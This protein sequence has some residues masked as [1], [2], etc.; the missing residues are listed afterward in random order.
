MNYTTIVKLI[1]LACLIAVLLTAC[2]TAAKPPVINS[3]EIPYYAINQLEV[4]N[5]PELIAKAVVI[6]W[7]QC[8]SYSSQLSNLLAASQI[9]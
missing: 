3:V 8:I 5:D 9:Q 6:S 2:T 4:T 7:K 1:L